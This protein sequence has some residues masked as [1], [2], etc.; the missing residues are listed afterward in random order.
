M[1]HPDPPY[2]KVPF[3]RRRFPNWPEE[4]MRDAEKI[5]LRF[6]DLQIRIFE[7]AELEERKKRKAVD[8]TGVDSSGI[9]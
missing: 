7:E 3:L 6:L 8:L 1:L 9:N 4:K 2:M 5:Y